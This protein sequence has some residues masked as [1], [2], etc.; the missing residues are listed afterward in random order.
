[1]LIKRKWLKVIVLLMMGAASGV[2]AVNPKEISEMIHI[3]N[4][5][6]IEYSIPDD[7]DDGD[8]DRR[9]RA[10]SASGVKTPYMAVDTARVNSCP[11]TNHF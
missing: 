1:V 7:S 8:G 4:E 2:G 6:K 9:R 10:H 11:V 3:M 5:Q